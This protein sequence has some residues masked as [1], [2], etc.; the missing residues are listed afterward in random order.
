MFLVQPTVVAAQVGPLA[1]LV[2]ALSNYLLT[3]YSPWHD[4]CRAVVV[5]YFSVCVSLLR[6]ICFLYKKVHTFSTIF[7]SSSIVI[8]VHF[9]VISLQ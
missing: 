9:R 4:F 5:V 2:G 7:L 1:W 8:F 6:L 3:W